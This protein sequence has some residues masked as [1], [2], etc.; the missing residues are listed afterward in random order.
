MLLMVC[1][2]SMSLCAAPVQSV[3]IDRA[4]INNGDV[5]VRVKVM[6]YGRN[7][8]VTYGGRQ[9]GLYTNV[10]YIGRPIVEGYY[11]TYNCGPLTRGHHT[12]TYRTH[13]QIRHG[14]QRVHLAALRTNDLNDK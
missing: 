13:L 11:Y 4:Y 10:S 2:F 3:E 9:L 14:I 6:G 8:Y 12:F 5:Y 1:S 7:E